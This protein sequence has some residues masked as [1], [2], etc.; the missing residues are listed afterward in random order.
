MSSARQVV[1][2]DSGPGALAL[3][4]LRAIE[5]LEQR[6]EMP[7]ECGAAA[8]R[9]RLAGNE[10]LA[11]RVHELAVLLHPIVEMRAGRQ[12]GR[13]HPADHLTLAHTLADADVGS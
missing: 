1:A 10:L 2:G 4:P 11:E 12:P 3:H 5:A 13:S 7:I 6:L 9:P 8:R